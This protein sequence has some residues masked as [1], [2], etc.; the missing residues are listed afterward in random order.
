M[1]NADK[2][3]LSSDNSA[4]DLFSKVCW[5]YSLNSFLLFKTNNRG[6]F[7]SSKDEICA[8]G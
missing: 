5:F 7:P 3:L 6:T 1:Q 4:V 8:C 2:I